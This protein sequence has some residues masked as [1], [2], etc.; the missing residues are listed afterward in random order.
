MTRSGGEGGNDFDIN[1]LSDTGNTLATSDRILDF[2]RAQGDS[3]NLFGIDANTLVDGND[4]FSFIGT[5]AF[6]AAG[7]LRY[8]VANGRTV[9]SGDVNGDGVADFFI[10]LDG[11]LTL[12]ADAFTL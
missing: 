3:I 5:A 8:E 7:Q 2:N 11:V 6:S 10:R 4:A 1:S 12:T 9:V